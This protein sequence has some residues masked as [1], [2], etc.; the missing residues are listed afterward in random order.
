YA[1]AA[2]NLTYTAL[3]MNNNFSSMEVE[4]AQQ[5]ITAFIAGSDDYFKRYRFYC[6]RIAMVHA[7]INEKD[8]RYIPPPTIWFDAANVNGF[9]GTEKWMANLE[10]KRKS[11]PLFRMEYK[12]LAEGVLEM[13]EEPV[14]SNY[15]YWKAYFLERGHDEIYQL[16]VSSIVVG[17]IN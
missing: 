9:Y 14:I 1:R 10:K 8:G 3:W 7:Y 11:L 13:I 15:N 12:A 17:I 5:F 4:F 16:F 6:Q 2:W